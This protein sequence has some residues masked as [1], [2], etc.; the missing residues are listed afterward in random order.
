MEMLLRITRPREIEWKLNCI[1]TDNSNVINQTA[2]DT[3]NAQGLE[4]G[5]SKST[6]PGDHFGREIFVQIL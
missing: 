3:L 1:V 6:F 4:R 5:S 2:L